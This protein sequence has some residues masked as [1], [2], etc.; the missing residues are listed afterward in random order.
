VAA[1]APILVV[2][3][4]LNPLA[5]VALKPVEQINLVKKNQKKIF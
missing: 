3:I 4:A 1:I 5:E 2:A